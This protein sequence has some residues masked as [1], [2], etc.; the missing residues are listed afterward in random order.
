MRLLSHLRLYT[1][2]MSVLNY[3][4]EPQTMTPRPQRASYSVATP[5][6]RGQNGPQTA[7]LPWTRPRLVKAL[8]VPTGAEA[9]GRLRPSTCP[10]DLS[11]SLVG[12]GDTGAVPGDTPVSPTFS[13]FSCGIGAIPGTGSS[14]GRYQGGTGGTGIAGIACFWPR[15]SWGEAPRTNQRCQGLPAPFPLAQLRPRLVGAT[16]DA[17]PRPP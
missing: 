7:S 14:R 4:G 5:P 15:R 2:T 8:C 17:W 3:P 6:T 12:W 13:L 1:T 10:A 9:T 16:P 11:I